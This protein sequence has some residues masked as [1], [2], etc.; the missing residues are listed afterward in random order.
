MKSQQ[1]TVDSQQKAESRMQ[2]A[3]S[4]S[5]ACPFCNSTD[6]EMIALFGPQMLTSQY[7]CNNCRTGFEAVKNPN[8]KFEVERSMS[9]RAE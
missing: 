6:N 8:S 5:V 7:Y 2:N 3:E 1:S 9:P 4:N